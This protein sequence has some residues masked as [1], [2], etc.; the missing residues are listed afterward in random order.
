MGFTV[1]YRHAWRRDLSSGLGLPLPRMIAHLP[2]HLERDFD[3]IRDGSCQLG[4]TSISSAVCVLPSP[5][6]TLSTDVDFPLKSYGNKIHSYPLHAWHHVVGGELQLLRRYFMWHI[7]TWHHVVGKELY[8]VCRSFLWYIPSMRSSDCQILGGGR[9]IEVR[10]GSRGI[11]VI[12][13]TSDKRDRKR[14]RHK[15]R[16]I[17]QGRLSGQNNCVA[18]V[19]ELSWLHQSRYAIV[20]VTRV[21]IFKGCQG[22]GRRVAV[23]RRQLP[24][25]CL[26]KSSF[27]SR[28]CSH[29]TS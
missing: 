21:I 9:V 12:S 27:R 26:C 22:Q 25:F 3:Y 16:I 7:P 4:R 20:G 28:S 23:I 18:A 14:S 13:Y 15:D 11:G 17:L 10:H 1:S 2:C 19:G 29:S 5:P 6:P 24:P 8:F